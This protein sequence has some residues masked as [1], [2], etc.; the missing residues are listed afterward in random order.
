MQE[1]MEDIPSEEYYNTYTKTNLN[2]YLSGFG[3][4]LVQ[5]F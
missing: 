4:G 1:V 5:C 2:S 3:W